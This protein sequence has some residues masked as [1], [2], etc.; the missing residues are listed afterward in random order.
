MRLTVVRGFRLDVRRRIEW[1]LDILGHLIQE[2]LFGCLE[3]DADVHGEASV[4][5]LI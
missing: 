4:T 1:L 2:E 5:R 3:W